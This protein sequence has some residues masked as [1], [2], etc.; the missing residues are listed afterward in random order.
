MGRAAC[1]RCGTALAA[2]RARGRDPFVVGRPRCGLAA[3][4]RVLDRWM[5]EPLAAELVETAAA[6]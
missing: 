2:G 1:L 3:A 5:R 6:V 4:H